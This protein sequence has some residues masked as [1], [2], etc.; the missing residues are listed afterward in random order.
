MFGK[1][2]TLKQLSGGIAIA[3]SIAVVAVSSAT[4]STSPRSFITD[5]LGGSGSAKAVPDV[6]DRYLTSHAPPAQAPG[7]AFI[8]DTLGGNG[9][10]KAV[11][12]VVDRYLA[13]HAAPAQ[14]PGGTFI[15]DTLGGNGQPVND[16]VTLS[17]ISSSTG[18]GFD[19]G[20]VGIAAGA[21]AGILLLMLLG[22]RLR[23]HKRGVLAA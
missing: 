18:S 16:G 9:S 10:A 14:A 22:T 7:A 23:G 17:K 8:T 20:N 12:D 6:I 4:A 5:T 1:H 11:P 2:H 3:V 13:S 21:A 19:W 15:T